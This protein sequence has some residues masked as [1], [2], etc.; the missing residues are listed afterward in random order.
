V[1]MSP[2]FI[3]NARHGWPSFEFHLV[4]RESGFTWDN[5]GKMIGGQMSITPILLYFLFAALWVAARRGF[6]KGDDIRYKFI[7]LTSLPTLLFFY[8]A[9]CFIHKAE[10]HWPALGYVP[11]V[12]GA[13][14]LYPEYLAK[15]GK[16]KLSDFSWIR[17]LGFGPIGRWMRRTSALKALVA[18]G[19]AF[20]LF[21]IVFMNVQIFY[22]LYRPEKTKYDITNDFYG[23]DK[24]A[25]RVREVSAEMEKETGRAPFIFSYHYNPASQL[26]WALKDWTNVY[27]LSRKTDQFDFWQDP[28]TLIGQDGVYI[29]NDAYDSPPEERYYFDRIEGPETI[30]TL[31]AGGVTGRTF[32][33][34]RCYGYRGMKE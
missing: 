34:Y 13:A 1:I 27:C 28:D 29:I 2:V 31:R 9:M 23:W 8:I 33:I 12:I 7:V 17:A 30:T 25:T 32:M 15:W 14:G 10:P 4:E 5:L 3:W 11:L 6:F 20:P 21:F 26:S 16:K 19:V 18:L 24:A 22:P